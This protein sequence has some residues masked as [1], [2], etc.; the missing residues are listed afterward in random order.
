M[1]TRPLRHG[2]ARASPHALPLSRRPV[3][4][5]AQSC[6][7]FAPS[8]TTVGGSLSVIGNG[9]V[10]RCD[11]RTLRTVGGQLQLASNSLITYLNAPALTSTAGLSVRANTI[12]TSLTFTNLASVGA[13]L[14]ISGT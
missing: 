13:D 11:M 3:P 8:L 6:D 1:L 14:V 4:C 2:T 5:R 12:L 10:Q 7:G 9:Q